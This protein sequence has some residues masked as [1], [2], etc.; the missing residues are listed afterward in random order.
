MKRSPRQRRLSDPRG[1]AVLIHTF[2]VFLAALWKITHLNAGQ[3]LDVWRPFLCLDYPLVWLSCYVAGPICES[4]EPCV[5]AVPGLAG[6]HLP[7][8]LIWGI[9]IAVFGGIQWFCIVWLFMWMAGVP[10]RKQTPG[11][12]AKC[13]CNLTANVSGACPEC[14]TPV[15]VDPT[16]GLGSERSETRTSR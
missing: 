9:C 2:V 15:P 8:E 4:V 16:A 1:I 10:W 12:C 14:G 3:A 7:Y 6:S 5:N 13:G 11:P